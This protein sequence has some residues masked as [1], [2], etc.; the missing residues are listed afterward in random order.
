M[1]QKRRPYS[2]VLCRGIHISILLLIVSDDRHQRR[3]AKR[4]QEAGRRSR[5]PTT[6]GRL[7]VLRDGPDGEAELRAGCSR[8]AVVGESFAALPWATRG[9]GWRGCCLSRAWDAGR[10]TPALTARASFGPRTRLLLQASARHLDLSHEQRVSEW[11]QC[12]GT[13]EWTTLGVPAGCR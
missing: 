5:R 1:R 6:I 7:Q 11:E 10:R 8:A 9:G 4:R 3:P 12:W 13:Y 2:G